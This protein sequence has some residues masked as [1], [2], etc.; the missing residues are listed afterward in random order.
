MYIYAIS[1]WRP[2]VNTCPVGIL[3]RISF[4]V[5][6]RQPYA[7]ANHPCHPVVLIKTRTPKFQPKNKSFFSDYLSPVQQIRKFIILIYTHLIRIY[8][9][10]FHLYY[11]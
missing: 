7:D 9:I 11:K 1:K 5:F 2:K 4:V 10:K 3:V 6:A 8:T